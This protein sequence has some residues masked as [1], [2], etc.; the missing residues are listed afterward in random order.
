M[1]KENIERAILRGTGQLKGEAIEQM[2]YEG[3]GPQGTA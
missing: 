3:Y 1:P 2:S